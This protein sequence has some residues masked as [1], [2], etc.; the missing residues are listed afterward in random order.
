MLKNVINR[1]IELKI[2]QKDLAKYLGYSHTAYSNIEKSSRNINSDIICKIAYILDI[3]LLC[4]MDITNYIE[5]L[6][7]KSKE[8]IKTKYKLDDDSIKKL[9]SN[10]VYN[11]TK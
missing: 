6:D 10:D 3:S 5:K 2:K 11:I 1:R 7:Y 4:V 9:Y 8:L